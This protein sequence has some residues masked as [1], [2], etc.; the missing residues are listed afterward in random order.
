MFRY[1]VFSYLN[2]FIYYGTK[3]IIQYKIIKLVEKLHNI[4]KKKKICMNK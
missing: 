2:V 1:L 4:Q 3:P